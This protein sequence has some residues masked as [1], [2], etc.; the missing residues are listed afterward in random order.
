[1]PWND[2]TKIM[3]SPVGIHDAAEAVGL[4]Y[5][6]GDLGDC[7]LN[8]PSFNKKALYIPFE[9][10]GHVFVMTDDIRK[11][12][13]W[14]HTYYTYSDIPT[15]IQAWSNEF[16]FFPWLEPQTRYRALDFVGYRSDAGD[17]FSL[18]PASSPVSSST[19]KV[20]WSLNWEDLFA[21]YV[22]KISGGSTPSVSNLNFGFL[23]TTVAP[24]SQFA[25]AVHFYQVTNIQE[26]MGT[27]ADITADEDGN[28]IPMNPGTVGE[29]N[30]Y[31]IPCFTDYVGYSKASMNL[32]CDRDMTG[33]TL[34]LFPFCGVGRLSITASGGGA[35]AELLAK[36]TVDVD[37]LTIETV[38]AAELIYRIKELTYSI[39]STSSATVNVGVSLS[40]TE[41]ISGGNITSGSVSVPGNDVAIDSPILLE[42]EGTWHRYQVASTDAVLL[43]TYS[44]TVNGE[45]AYTTTQFPLEN[46]S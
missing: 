27:L 21:T 1:M 42:R 24:S 12:N 37:L 43:I 29:G 26:T 11:A 23:M 19:S 25:G 36:F 3:T 16:T 20:L 6:P 46:V 10:P 15:A 17:W 45:T 9:D 35:A 32:N 5:P 33:S 39:S 22:T 7:C 28:R 13:N 18:T 38:S 44:V 14:G 4:S 8:G 31:V 40:I 34:Y 30:W 2:T 41:A